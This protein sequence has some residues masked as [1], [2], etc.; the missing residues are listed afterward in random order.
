M[1]PQRRIIAIAGAGIAGLTAAL[2]LS[3]V[4][5]RV[6]LFE[7]QAEPA[8]T[9]TGIQISPNAFH[10]LEGL[11]LDRSV[12]AAGFSPD[13]IEIGLGMTGSPLTEF[14]LGQT[15]LNRHG[16]PYL[17]LH[18]VDLIQILET[19]CQAR[20][21]I[22]LL[23]GHSVCEIA[24]HQNGVTV[25]SETQGGM[26]E[27]VVSAV[28]GADGTWSALRDFIPNA[29]KPKF[30]D[31]IAWRALA[32][33]NTISESISRHATGL[34]LGS[35]A[36]LV[37]YPIRQSQLL[38]IIA[39]TRWRGE[40]APKPGWLRS[41]KDAQRTEPFDD[42]APDL[43]ELVSSSLDWGGWPVFSVDK[44]GPM[45]HGSICLIGDAAHCMV[46]FGAQGGAAAL[47]DAQL[48]ARECENSPTDLVTAFNNYA[49]LRKARL[50][51]IHA[52]SR[53]NGIIYHLPAPLSYC[54][55]FAIKRI[56]QERLQRRMD[57]LYGW[58][59][60]PRG[61]KKRG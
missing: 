57:W 23:R 24:E 16:A 10:V 37:H 52:L 11:E 21:D 17:V 8:Q 38:N 42:W 29:Q 59:G 31:K 25:M 60:A 19:A 22:E 55:N 51:S 18:R 44:I 26:R 39:I 30:T 50:S 1:K 54:R 3:H 6:L 48:L 9:G 49:R 46:P 20:E 4:G 5:F 45:N 15:A 12:K 40:T 36:H 28:I 53:S 33:I 35:G 27:D 32:N 58:Q 56:S 7:K 61:R 13:S 2:C 41:G 47:E 14:E 34:W 43:R